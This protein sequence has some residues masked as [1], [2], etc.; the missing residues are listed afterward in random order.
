MSMPLVPAGS[1][2][3]AVLQDR[4][5][6]MQGLLTLSMVMTEG[7]D[8]PRILHLASSAVASLGHAHLDGLFVSDRGWRLTRGPCSEADVRADVEAQFAVLDVVGGA[9]AIMGE[10]WGWAYPLR[11]LEGHFGF[12]LVAA[13]AQPDTYE[14]FLLRVL[15][16]QTGIALANARMHA[17]ERAIADELRATNAALAAAVAAAELST[18]I[19]DRLTQ[20]AFFGE[21]QEGI[22]RA[23]HELTGYPVA[24]EDQ[25][26]NLRA[27]AG[28]A[29]DPYPREE[30]AA[31][32]ELMRRAQQ[33]GRP[34][35]EGA[36][37]IA[38]AH[39]GGAGLGVLVL[40]D[41]EG[42]AGEQGV[43][44]LEHGATVLAM[45]LARLHSL[46]ESELRVTRD[47]VEELL[48]GA[49]AEH[50]LA[51][52]Q[53]LGYELQRPHRVLVVESP[54]GIQEEGALLHAVRLAARDTDAGS[55]LA[56]RSQSVV[57]LSALSSAVAAGGMDGPWEQLR[58]AIR[59]R[60]AGRTCRIGVGGRC[61]GPAD[62]P[63]SYREAQLALRMQYA[64]GG[65]GKVTVFDQLGVYRILA[66]AQDTGTIERFVREWLGPLLDYDA[67]KRTDLVPTLSSYLEHGGS[68]DAAAKAVAVHRST[69]KYR[70]QRI[71]EISGLDLSD[72][73]TRFSL[74]LAT[75]ARDTL[76]ALRDSR[77]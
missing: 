73:E 36:R 22:A 35:R 76:A 40:F 30:P 56:P 21:G 72:P 39:P 69:L 3:D 60:L 2:S 49:D 52:A 48:A 32:E 64:S 45:D 5:S 1:G 6:T 11:S 4:L 41:V 54:G 53:A 12:L 62:F 42:T 23:V 44:A 75:R 16:Q 26:G 77:S 37:L 57:V 68:Y 50:A 70:L 71:R 61:D 27:R 46:A 28:P 33:A 10:G 20:V 24:V 59:P 74:Q 18:T 51:L 63:R 58:S 7:A 8:E 9:V 43:T 31:R 19:H 17:R 38:V 29:P 34:I 67:A 65:D 66:E 13:E 14:Q 25:Y 47:L 15:A 55:L